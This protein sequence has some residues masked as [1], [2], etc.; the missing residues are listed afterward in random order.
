MPKSP[1][2]IRIKEQVLQIVAS[3]PEAQITT[4]RSIGEHL[5]VVPRHV[6]YILSMLSPEEKMSYPWHRVVSENGSLGVLKRGPDGKTQAE[7][8]ENEGHVISRNAIG[9]S[10]ERA[11]IPAVKLES[12]VSKQ[13]RPTKP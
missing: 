1:A 8:L 13:T 2:F 12:D 5:D 6:A 7:L 4:H 3:V 10:F 9:L 11:F